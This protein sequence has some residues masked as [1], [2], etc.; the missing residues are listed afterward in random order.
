MEN[1]G[2]GARGRGI[3]LVGLLVALTGAAEAALTCRAE[4]D[5]DRVAPGGQIVLTLSAA[6]DVGRQPAFEVPQIEGVEI[7]SGGTSQ[8]FSMDASGT[9]VEFAATYYLSVRRATDFRIPAVTFQSG[10]QTCRTD[11]IA[12]TV[13]ATQPPPTQ[14]GNR[15][16]RPAGPPAGAESPVASG[17]SAGR[18][19]DPVFIT[20]TADKESVWLGEQVILVFR[21]YRQRNAWDQ[22][23][24]TPPR[25]EGFWRVDLPPERNY[26]TSVQGLFYE[27]T[28]IRYALFPTS[29][30]QLVIEPAALT[31]AGDPFERLF[32]RRARGPQQ[33]VTAPITVT[34]RDLPLPR[35]AAFG[36]IV[37]SRLAFTASVDRDTV[38]RGEPVA[39]NLQVTAAGF[40]KSFKGLELPEPDGLRLHGAGETLREDVSGPRYEATF[41]QE[42]AVVPTR[43]GRVALPPLE[44]VYFDA[45]Q[46]V[47]R[48]A[49]AA[50]PELVVTPSDLPTAG[51]DPSGF[52]RNEIARLGRDLA[53][54]HPVA[55]PVRRL[56][57]ALVERPLW[58]AG[59]IGPW[60]LLAGYRVRLRRLAADQR[61]PVG[62]RR[63]TAWPQARRALAQASRTADAAELARAILAYVAARAGRAAAGLTAGEAQAWCEERGPAACG[64]LPAGSPAECDR[65]RFGGAAALD[66]AAC[67]QEVERLLGGLERAAG[68]EDRAPRTLAGLGLAALLCLGPAGQAQD[69]LPAAGPAPGVDPARLVAEGNQ[70]YTDGDLTVAVQR[71]REALALGADDATVHY[72]LGNAYARSG[73]LGRAIASYQRA[74]RRAPRNGDIRT[75]LAWVRSHTRDLELVGQGLPPVVAQLDAAA[76]RLALDEWAAVLVVLSWLTAAQVAWIWRRGWLAAGPRRMLILAGA[77]LI[78]VGVITASRWYEEGWR[79][80]AVVIA[81]EVEVRSGPATTFPVVFRIHDGLSLVVRGEREGWARIALGG[82]WVGWVPAGTLER[83]RRSDQGR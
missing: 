31:L 48:T 79:D 19:G 44:L 53:F 8:S 73:E 40:L 38:P 82:D 39:L 43:Q 59:L 22:P 41:R 54:I 71:Y 56:G 26:R 3:A 20:L 77:L 33:L 49:R 70:A 35:P 24:Y 37:A 25:T 9:H 12:I 32:G 16:A 45:A 60:L 14:T 80:T 10:G 42:T 74:Q 50:V 21:Y 47:Y 51:D 66:V 65:V 64:A 18:P 67:A 78:A 83:V 75:N 7:V 58:W 52:R 76:H 5:R 62:L 57:P 61:D 72:N 29:S 27:V 63:R 2:A 81:P 13:D 6:G 11:A 68:R 4:V 30:G 34:V 15:T 46:G 23:S 28:E 17:R 1:R 55:G 36:G 69:L